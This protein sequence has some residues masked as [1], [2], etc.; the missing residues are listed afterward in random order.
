MIKRLFVFFS[1]LCAALFLGSCSDSLENKSSL[2]FKV[3]DAFFRDVV[4]DSV[5]TGD[6]SQ[7]KSYTVKV[8]VSWENK[9]NM[10]QEQSVTVND[11]GEISCP[12]LLLKI[13]LQE[14]Q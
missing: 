5:S 4:G 8:T 1:I 13:C 12:T 6:S 9:Q 11:S 14:K 10:V 7:T 3:S 2:A